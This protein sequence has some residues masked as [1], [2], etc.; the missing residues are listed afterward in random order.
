MTAARPTRGSPARRAASSVS[1]S[2]SGHMPS[3]DRHGR[4]WLAACRIHSTPRSASLMM[5]QVPE[6]FG[7]DQPGPGAFA[8]DLDQECA[9][10]VA[11]TGGP[12]GVHARGA[13]AG[14]EGGGAAFEAGLGFDDQRHAVAGGVEVDHFRDQAVEAFHGD[15]GCGVSGFCRSGNGAGR[16]DFRNFEGS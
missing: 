8:P 16:A 13:V 5:L 9:L 11:E 3:S 14:G 7:I 6:R 2:L 12:L 10:A 4:S 15:V 1:K